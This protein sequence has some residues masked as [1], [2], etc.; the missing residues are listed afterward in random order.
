GEL[1]PSDDPQF[2]WRSRLVAAR[3]DRRLGRTKEAEG[4]LRAAIAFLES[5][6]AGLAADD[7]TRAAYLDDKLSPF[8]ELLDLLVAQGRAR[9]AFAVLE[10]MRA[11]SLEAA[12]A[13]GN[14]R[15]GAAPTADES[16]RQKSLEGRLSELNRE[17]LHAPRPDPA[18]R[19]RLEEARRD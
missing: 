1:P 8:R 14:V 3:A 12:L 7:T 10:R 16:A 13:Q 5:R 9:D 11:Q 6:R 17:I 18:L 2:I 15:A 19:A 4:E